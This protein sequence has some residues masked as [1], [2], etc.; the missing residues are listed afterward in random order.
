MDRPFR[1]EYHGFAQELK[2]KWFA[3]EVIVNE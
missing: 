3:K 2:M 1:I